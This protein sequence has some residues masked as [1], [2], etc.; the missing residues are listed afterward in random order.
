MIERE[1]ASGRVSRRRMMH[2]GGALVAA[3]GGVALSACGAANSSPAGG[4][5]SDAA[6]SQAPAT[7]RFMR[8][9]GEPPGQEPTLFAE[10]IP[11]FQAKYPHIKIVDEQVASGA[12]F[13]DKFTVLATGGSLGDVTWASVGAGGIYNLVAQ[14]TLMALDPI[15]SRDKVDL[16]QYYKGCVDGLKRD[17]KLWGLPFKAHPGVSILFYN[18]TEF[19]RAGAGVPD[20]TWTLDKFLD[21]AKKVTKPDLYGFNP[22]TS[23]KTILTFVR[24]FGGELLD[25]DGKKS[26]LNQPAALDA[27]TWMYEAF[28]RHNIAPKPSVVT[29]QYENVDKAFT[30][31]KL[32]SGKWGTSFQ[33]TAARDVKDSFKWFASL[34]PKGRGNVGGSDYE[35][36]A[37]SITATSKV[38]DQ[39]FEWVKWL[40]NQESGIRLG[41]IGGTVGGRP[42]VYKSERLL[43]DPVRRVFLEAMDTAQPGRPLYNT[44]M[45]EYERVIEQ[46]L[47]PVWEGQQAPTKSFMDELTRQVQVV[48]DRPLP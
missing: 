10:Q 24:A 28:N 30:N 8:R 2:L 39:S 48:L 35:I 47:M 18:Q 33:A 20:K 17:G 27:I 14:K 5:G 46:G 41:E 23:Q 43:K 11:L 7:I 19:E 12:E 3:G 6:K 32:A 22:A 21:A 15:I 38:P 13:Y 37:M 42:D 34:M 36:D 4:T 9:S 45:V 29:A 1:L 25:A 26:Q 16:N 31:G 44:R 40:T